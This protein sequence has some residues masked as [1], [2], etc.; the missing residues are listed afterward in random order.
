[1]ILIERIAGVQRVRSVKVVAAGGQ[2]QRIVRRA[3]VQRA[4]SVRVV[5]V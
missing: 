2:G 3:G 1:V 4:R 5:A